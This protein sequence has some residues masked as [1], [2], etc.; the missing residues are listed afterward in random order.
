[1]HEQHHLCFP[2][3]ARLK[4]H[5][6]WPCEYSVPFLTLKLLSFCCACSSVSVPRAN[7]VSVSMRASVRAMAVNACS[8]LIALKRT[9]SLGR[10]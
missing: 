3:A 8:R 7:A 2:A 6:P 1:M 10:T 4:Q 5:M 9:Y